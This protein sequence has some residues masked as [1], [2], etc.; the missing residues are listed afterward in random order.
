VIVAA[1]GKPVRRNADISAFVR[2]LTAGS[3]VQLQV[4]RSGKTM[5][6]RGKAAARP[7][8]SYAGADTV[9]GAVPF[10]GGHLRDILVTP[11]GAERPPVLFLIQGFSCATVETANPA[12]PYRQIGNDLVAAGIAFYRVEKPQVGDSRG[13]P[14]CADTDFATELDAFRSAYRSLI[15]R[16]FEADRIFILGHSMGGIQAPLLAAELPPRG[17]AVYGTGLKNWADYHRDI[18]LYQNYLFTGTDPAEQAQRAARTRKVIDAFYFDRLTPAEIVRRDPAAAPLLRE[19]FSWDGGDRVF[20]RNY[21]F[22]QDLAQLPMIRAWRDTRSNVLAMYGESDVVALFDSDHQVI[23]DIADFHRPGS[24]RYRSFP[25]TDH[26]MG[27]VGTRTE[28]R[29]K[30][31]AAAAPPSGPFNPEVAAALVE[32]IRASMAKPPVRTLNTAVQSKAEAR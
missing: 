8:E 6:M 19:T 12:A 32:W 18:D 28:L 22:T 14:N 23:A 25:G 2:D 26:G 3:P 17:V 31:R 20:G 10:A 4:R 1:G 27:V 7:R 16:G 24:G 30:T 11:Q 9:Y 5:T 15:A 29:E 13:G 21:R